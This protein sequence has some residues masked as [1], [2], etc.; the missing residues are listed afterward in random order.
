M[1]VLQL[2]TE[3]ETPKGRILVVDDSRVIR[4]MVAETL[5]RAGFWVD[6]AEDGAAALRR[7]GETSFD[8]VITDIQMPKMDGFALMS[9]ARSLDARPEVIVITATHAEDLKSAVRALRMGA[10]DFLTK[11]LR[12]QDDVALTVQRA[13]E[14]KRDRDRSAVLLRELEKLSRTDPLTGTGNRRAFDEALISEERRAQRY[15]LPLG[16]IL[17]DLDHFK[18][19]NDTHGHGTGDAVLQ[20]FAARVEGL[21]RGGD[22][23]YRPGGDEFAV[24][25]PHTDLEG[26]LSVA[27]RIVSEVAASP[28]HAGSTTLSLTCSAGVASLLGELCSAAELTA[29]ADAALYAAKSSG[30]NRTH[31]ASPSLRRM[32]RV[33][34][35]WLERVS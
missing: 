9:A 21:L 16:M 20:R 30:R 7:L 4:T 1:N 5:T 24:L 18:P 2:G 22:S 32:A 25:L 35:L 33:P 11:P 8:V 28:F 17:L 14:K 31:P 13:V 27:R 10:H 29:Q 19:V 3:A 26:A 23:L 12:D 34:E 15:D 6:V